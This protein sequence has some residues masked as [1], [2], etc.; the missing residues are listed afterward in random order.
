MAPNPAPNQASRPWSGAPAPPRPLADP[1]VRAAVVV[2]PLNLFDAAG[3]KPVRAPVQRW[4]SA[5]G[6]DGVEPAHV[7]A[8]RKALPKQSTDHQVADGAGHFVFLAPCTAVLR[9]FAPQICEDPQGVNR[10]A[11]HRRMNAAAVAFFRQHLR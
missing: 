6:G 8:I 11:L 3:L 4:A 1:R 9:S 7:E 2:D 5:L 10:N